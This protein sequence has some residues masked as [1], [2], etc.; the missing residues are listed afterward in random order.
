[1]RGVLVS[2]GTNGQKRAKGGGRVVFCASVGIGATKG[3][4]VVY[5]GE[6]LF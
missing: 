1:M 3:G 4:P 2:C 6:Q 5:M